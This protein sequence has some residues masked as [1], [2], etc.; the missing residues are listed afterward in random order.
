MSLAISSEILEAVVSTIIG[1]PVTFYFIDFLTKRS[2]YRKF[3]DKLEKIAGVNAPILFPLSPP[4]ASGLG[5]R[6]FKITEI[7]SQGLVLEDNMNKVF[8]PME[9]VLQTEILLPLADYELLRKER[10]K[11]D[12]TDM[13][14]AMFPPMIDKIKELFVTELM[15]DKTKLSAVVGL[16]VTS[17]L[18][19]AGVDTSKIQP[20]AS[21]RELMEEFEKTETKPALE[22]TPNALIEDTA[23]RVERCKTVRLLQIS[24][25]CYPAML[26][27]SRAVLTS[28][29][30]KSPPE[31][32]YV[33]VK[34][35]L[36]DK[37]LLEPQYAEWLKQLED[38]SRK[39]EN[40]ELSEVT[41]V[42]VDEWI[43]KTEKYVQRMQSLLSNL[44][45]KQIR[46]TR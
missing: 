18:R 31:K 15:D 21:F 30:F 2:N 27:A 37:G 41:A 25:D 19:Q 24:Q 32:T 28:M 40:D 29:G 13:M 3:K 26:N 38:M 35:Q 17:Q 6:T 45:K 14:D 46:G 43:Q 8:V 23:K 5:P 9:K 42:L 36:V 4:V 7:S 33:L 12:F 20:T 44:S 22:A 10:M 1:I 39:I 11:K 16:R 34:E